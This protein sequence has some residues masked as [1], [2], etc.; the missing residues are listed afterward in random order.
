MYYIAVRI[1]P[2]GQHLAEVKDNS[3]NATEHAEAV[4]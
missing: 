1:E 4:A 3:G 2:I